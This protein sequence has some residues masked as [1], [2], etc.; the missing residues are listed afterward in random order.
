MNTTNTTEDPITLEEAA[1]AYEKSVDDW[2]Y[3]VE[4][5]RHNARLLNDVID[6]AEPGP[7]TPS[8][9]TVRARLYASGPCRMP[10][11]T[12]WKRTFPKVGPGSTATSTPTSSP[13]SMTSSTPDTTP[14]RSS[15]RPPPR[16]PSRSAPTTA[17]SAWP[18]SPSKST[19]SRAAAARHHLHL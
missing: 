17:P 15:T 8:V 10:T 6:T 2:L 16:C 5:L 4:A 18:R 13:L 9:V 12:P 14:T 1:A 11:S 19:V 3:A 7:C